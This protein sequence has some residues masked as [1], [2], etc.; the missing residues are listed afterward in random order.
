[1]WKTLNEF[2]FL[3]QKPGTYNYLTRHF[4]SEWDGYQCNECFDMIENTTK[5]LLNH[6]I[7]K[8]PELIKRIVDKIEWS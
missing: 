3:I 7:E 4:F 2:R 1:M 5:G 6:L 8:H